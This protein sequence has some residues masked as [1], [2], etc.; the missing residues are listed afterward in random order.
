MR[1]I[2]AFCVVGV[3]E[4]AWIRP[5]VGRE[6]ERWRRAAAQIPDPALRRDALASLRTKRFNTEGAA[7]FAVLPRRRDGRLLR[8]L[9]A[10]QV[11]L[12][13]LDTLS[14]RPAP[15]PLANAA[16]LHLALT[17]ALDPERPMSDYYRHHPRRADG[18]YVHALVHACRESCRSLPAYGKVRGPALQAATRCSVQGLN[19]D[20]DPARRDSGLQRWAQR[21]YPRSSGVSWWELTAAASS[22]LG[23]HAL[24]ALA[25]DP[26]CSR[27]DAAEVAGAYMPWICAASTMLD[28]YVDEAED[29]ANNG[30]S[31]MAHYPSTG[32]AAQ[33]TR[34]LLCRSLHEARRL[35]NGPRHVL[36]AAGMV[37]MYLSC[38][39]ART[40][41]KRSTTRAFVRSGG[42]L[43]ILLLP[44][45][46]A[47]RIAHALRTM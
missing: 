17:D 35:R 18:G 21:T 39:A 30:H 25:A 13:F 23:I 3:R 8:V 6:V 15:D 42:L 44:V 4:L 43:A 45:L 41:A 28:S 14:E 37:A 11:L 7:L 27:R 2:L 9:V 34:E 46:R 20:P 19:H 29:A 26:A 40:S 38:E 47:W 16:Q 12:D 36:I 22:T 5:G 1:Q 31:Y 24:L 10:F 33:R 32:I